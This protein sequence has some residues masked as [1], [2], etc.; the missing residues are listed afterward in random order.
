M[1]KIIIL[2][3]CLS[4]VGVVCAQDAVPTEIMQR[5]LLIKNDAANKYG[6]AFLIDRKGVSP[7]VHE[8]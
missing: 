7:I 1:R 5:T 8:Q 6:T 3:V 4:L 2:A